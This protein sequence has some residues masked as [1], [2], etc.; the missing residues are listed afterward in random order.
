MASALTACVTNFC[1]KSGKCSGEYEAVPATKTSDRT[2]KALKECAKGSELVG[3]NTGSRRTSAG[4]CEACA[5][6]SHKNDAHQ[7]DT[8]C[9]QCGVGKFG[10]AKHSRT[11]EH[12]C[13]NCPS[14]Q[15]RDASGHTDCVKCDAGEYQQGSGA[16]ASGGSSGASG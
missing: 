7:W 4:K 13:L 9:T 8:G 11:G 12:H 16:T 6:G 5:Q 2:C 14:G 1:D 10:S 3:Y 15:F